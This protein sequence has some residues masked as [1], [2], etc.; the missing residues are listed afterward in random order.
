MTAN[1]ILWTPSIKLNDNTL[2]TDVFNI[3]NYAMIVPGSNSLTI[4]LCNNI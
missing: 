1:T 4:E 2:R 3:K